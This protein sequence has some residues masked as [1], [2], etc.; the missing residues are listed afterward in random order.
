MSESP[1]PIVDEAREV[2]GAAERVPVGRAAARRVAVELEAADVRICRRRERHA[3]EN[4]CQSYENRDSREPPEGTHL[5]H[6]RC[7]PSLPELD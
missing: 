1:V 2:E 5:P 6:L 3:D 4:R 7:L